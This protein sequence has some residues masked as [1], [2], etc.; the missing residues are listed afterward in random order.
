MLRQERI[1]LYADA[2]AHAV[3]LERRLDAVWAFG[4]DG[5]SFDI[6]I[7]PRGGP[8]TLASMDEI[9]VRMRLLADTEVAAAWKALK[10]GL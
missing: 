5:S 2:L 9:S 10:R 7:R 8:V 6:S 4:G 1:R 3:D